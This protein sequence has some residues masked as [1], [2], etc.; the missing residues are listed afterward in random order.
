MKSFRKKKIRAFREIP[1]GKVEETESGG[2]QTT[3]RMQPWKKTQRLLD[4][5]HWQVKEAERLISKL[6]AKQDRGEES[7][8]EDLESETQTIELVVEKAK[9]RNAIKEEEEDKAETNTLYPL[10]AVYPEGFNAVGSPKE[11]WV[12]AEFAV[13]SGATD[14]VMNEESLSCIETTAGMAFRQGVEYAVMP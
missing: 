10:K 8:Q 3:S 5:T 13:D 7:D 2:S 1:K 14:T 4:Q 11:E 12:E 6:C 9:K